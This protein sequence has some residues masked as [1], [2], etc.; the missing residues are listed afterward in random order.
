MSGLFALV[1]VVAKSERCKGHSVCCSVARSAANGA[2]SISGRVSGSFLISRQDSAGRDNLVLS[3]CETCMD[4][5]TYFP[6]ETV[7]GTGTGENSAVSSV[8]TPKTVSFATLPP[9]R[10]ACFLLFCRSPSTIRERPPDKT[11]SVT[12]MCNTITQ[13]NILNLNTACKFPTPVG[14]DLERALFNYV[15][16]SNVLYWWHIS[17]I[18]I[19]Q[20]QELS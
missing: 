4:L 7:Q 1:G 6:I 12:P 11:S 3:F 16:C 15:Y 9:Q 8:L 5:S 19:P 14:S 10:S 17:S 20:E 2:T 18:S 13:S